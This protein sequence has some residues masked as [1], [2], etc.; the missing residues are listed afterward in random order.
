MPNRT[1]LGGVI[2]TYQK[3]DPKQFPSPTQ[4]PPDLVSPAFEHML[5]FGDM[6]EL[7]DEELARAV[8]LDPSQIAG[9][10]PSLESLMAVLK[11]RKRKI[12][13]TY[14][15]GTVQDA[16]KKS[17]REFGESISPP[18][19][20]RKQFQQAFEEEQIRELER[21]WYQVGNDR[22]PL[23]RQIVQLVDR[24]GDKYQVDEL[25]GKYEFTGQ[26]SLTVPEALR[27]QRRI[28]NNRPALEAV[29]RGRENSADR[30]DRHGSAR[31]IRRT[32]RHGSTQR[33][34]AA[35]RELSS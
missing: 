10:G 23:A 11:E 24:L 15:T 27:D 3:Y 17:Y 16:A 14:E 32:G 29:G 31:A 20:L 12:L 33:I 26:T 34:A 5:M 13:A 25:A 1:S 4:P 7:T 9:L 8:Q 30:L 21:V 18:K 35:G 19:P 28:R 2:H 22:S 6:R